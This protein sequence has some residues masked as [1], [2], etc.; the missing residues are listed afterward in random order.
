MEECAQGQV[1]DQKEKEK[2]NKWDNNR[3]GKKRQRGEKR[4]TSALS[5]MA[6]CESLEFSAS[7]L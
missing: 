5:F 3:V 6:I 4:N 1:K 2:N 7:G